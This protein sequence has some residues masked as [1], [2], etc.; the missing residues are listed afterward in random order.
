MKRI[1]FIGDSI[2]SGYYPFV[3]EFLNGKAEIY[4]PED[5]CRWAQYTLRCMHEWARVLN[6]EEID[7][8]HWNN[9]LWDL[10]RINGD[11][12]LTELRDYVKMLKRVYTT[13]GESSPSPATS[14]TGSVPDE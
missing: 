13:I 14:R 1:F 6:G 4:T 8:V 11:I 7:I 10:L 12:P 3:Q 9:G 2:R 5:N